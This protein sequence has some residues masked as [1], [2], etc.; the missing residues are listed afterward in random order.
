MTQ[1]QT[2]YVLLGAALVG[3]VLIGRY[4]KSQAAAVGLPAVVALALPFVVGAALR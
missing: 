4:V 3:Q 2:G 1:K